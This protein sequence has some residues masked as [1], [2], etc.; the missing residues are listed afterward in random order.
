MPKIVV[1]GVVVY[2][3]GHSNLLILKELYAYFGL[4]KG[5]YRSFWGQKGR[6]R[7]NSESYNALFDAKKCNIGP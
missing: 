6:Y 3:V 1:Y 5:L 2:G 4:K 7:K